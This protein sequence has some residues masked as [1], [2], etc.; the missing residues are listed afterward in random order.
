MS[1]TMTLSQFIRARASKGTAATAEAAE[2][3]ETSAMFLITANSDQELTK[4][5]NDLPKGKTGKIVA[6]QFAAIGEAIGAAVKAM[7]D[8]LPDGAGWIGSKNGPF[9]KATKEAR[10]PYLLALA[11]AKD[12]FTAS[13]AASG[14]FNDVVPKTAEEKEAAK[15]AKAAEAETKAAEAKAAIKKAL[16][17][18]G[19]VVP[20]DSIVKV[21]DCATSMLVDILVRR[22]LATFSSETLA[23]LTA[24]VH[25]L[26]VAEMK[27]NGQLA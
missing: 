13:L 18:S 5:L 2:A 23:L 14:H 22:D 26:N 24:H 1:T 27:A 6:G 17:E 11:T 16:I 3:F 25:A 12:A 10:A 21:D 19:E 8:V 4:A 15:A 7:R 9:S 20:A